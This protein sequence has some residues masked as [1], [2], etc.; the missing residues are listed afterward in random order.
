M[1]TQPETRHILVIGYHQPHP[2]LSNPN[3]IRAGVIGLQSALTLLEEGQGR[4]KVSIVAEY[5]P[6]DDA[7]IY[8]SAW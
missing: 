8:A 1:A 7:G 5:M 4:Y 2:F 6:G 3:H